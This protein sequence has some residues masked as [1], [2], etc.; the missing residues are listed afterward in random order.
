MVHT[1]DTY[2]EYGR[3]VHAEGTHSIG[4]WYIQRVHTDNMGGWYIQMG[5]TDSL[6][7]SG[8]GTDNTLG[9]KLKAYD[10]TECHNS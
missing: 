9:N 7:M 10:T 3:L 6:Y 5:H 2:R 8:K 4:G 1:D